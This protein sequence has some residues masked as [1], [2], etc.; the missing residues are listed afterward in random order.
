MEDKPIV[1]CGAN[2][3]TQKYYFNEEFDGLPEGIKKELQIMCVWFVQEVGGIFLMEFQ[4]DGTLE[5]RTEANEYDGSIDEIGSYLKI[6]QMRE[7]RRE[8][9]TSLELYFKVFFLGEEAELEESGEESI[10]KDG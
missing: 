6:K 9:L 10:E 3:Y 2:A 1:L 5:F 8:L 4:E 7:E